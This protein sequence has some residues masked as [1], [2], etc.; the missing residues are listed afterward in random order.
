MIKKILLGLVL[1]VLAIGAYAY[2]TVMVAPVV[3]ENGGEQIVVTV[4]TGS[5]YEQVMDTLAANG[6]RPNRLFFDPI[7][8]RMAFKREDMRAGRYRLQPGLST[9]DLIRELRTAKRQTADV[10]LNV[11]RE[12]PNVAAKAARFLEPDSLAFVT[13]MQDEDY[14]KSIGY[15]KETLQTL[16]LP[17]TYELYWNST[18]QEFMERMIKEHDRFWT[19]DR[20]AKAKVQGLT[21]AEAYTLASIVQS[22]S[23]AKSEQPR[24]AGLYLNRLK[25]G[26]ALQSDPTAVFANRVFGIKR[27]LFKHIELDHPYNTYVYPGLPP[28]PI[29]MPTLSAIEAVL[30]PEDHDY[31]YMCAVG[32]NSG[33][34]NFAKNAAGHARNKAIYV[35]NLKRRGLR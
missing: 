4:P 14:L 18:P 11:E 12:F 5:S 26:I 10:V 33:L 21:P 25:R 20:T 6:I 31:I 8:E 3:P 24:I 27:V 22:E 28:G 29:A 35:A 30:N 1:L 16:F 15:T 23:L 2:Y 9:V 19:P 7:A 32:D 13:L 34:H 17:N